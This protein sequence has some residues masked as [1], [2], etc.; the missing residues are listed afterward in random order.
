MLDENLSGEERNQKIRSLRE[1]AQRARS[2]AET[3]LDPKVSANLA[4]YAE[5]LESEAARLES[6]E[7][8]S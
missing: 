6:A 1:N 7:K 5:E 2:F 3:A 8:R 4:D